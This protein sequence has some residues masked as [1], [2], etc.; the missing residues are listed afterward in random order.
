[1]ETLG[2][3]L[4]AG[5]LLLS[6]LVFGWVTIT[7][8]PRATELERHSRRERQEQLVKLACTDLD[9]EYRELLNH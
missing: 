3:W 7:T 6:A 8:H 9:A 5:T 4:V 1:M 2:L